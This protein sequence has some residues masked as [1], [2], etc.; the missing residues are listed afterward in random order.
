ITRTT[1]VPGTFDHP[2]P[3]YYG[4]VGGPPSM[5]FG[6]L[7]GYPSSLTLHR[8]RY[9]YGP[10][11]GAPGP[12]SLLSPYGPTGPLGGSLSF[13]LCDDCL[14]FMGAAVYGYGP[15]HVMDAYGGPG[16]VMDGYGGPG[17]IMDR[18]GYGYRGSPMPVQSNFSKYIILGF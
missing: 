4:D 12:Y 2:G 11:S 6:M 16:P 10:P 3:S 17:P 14:P 1:P 9:G 8:M 7:S 13:S 18:Y 5:R 15:G